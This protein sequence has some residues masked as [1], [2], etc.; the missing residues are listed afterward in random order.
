FNE[1]DPVNTPRDLDEKNS[2]VIKAMKDAIA[3][4]RSKHIPM[5]STW[6]SLQ[7]AG[8]TGAPAIPLGGGLGDQAGNANALASRQPVANR[9]HYKPVTYGSSHIQAI[10]FLDGGRL[11]AYTI[12]TYGQ[13]ENPTSPWSKDQTA[14]FGQKK[15]VTFA[16]TPAQIQAA[17]VSQITV[18]SG[19]HAG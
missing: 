15:W 1:A 4:L 6:G 16:F 18:A 7:V 9:G 10:S 13:S 19:S 8:D 3:F 17:R 11:L 2:D 14:M 5:N 12:L